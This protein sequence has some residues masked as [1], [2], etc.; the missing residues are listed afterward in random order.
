MFNLHLAG[1][2]V[3]AAICRVV[4]FWYL[5]LALLTITRLFSRFS[6]G[7]RVKKKKGDICI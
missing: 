1:N 6:E 2:G 4:P 7:R 3:V 5:L